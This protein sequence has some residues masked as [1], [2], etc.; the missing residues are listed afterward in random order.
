MSTCVIPGTAVSS[1]RTRSVT[2]FRVNGSTSPETAT[3]TTCCRT[4]ISRMTGFSVSIGK[5]VMAS[6][7]LLTSSTTRRASASRSSSIITVPIPSEAVDWICL[8]PSMPWIASSMR[9]FT[10]SSTSSGA[11]PRYGTSTLIRSSS[12]SGND[13]SRTFD[14]ASTPLTRM[15]AIIRLAATLL[16]ANQSIMRLKTASDRTPE[17]LHVPPS[18]CP[19]RRSSLRDRGGGEPGSDHSRCAARHGRR[20]RSSR[21]RAHTSRP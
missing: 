2:R 1:S 14:V 12:I 10:A 7:L 17:S 20:C 11:A 19:T 18:P 4:V 6:M 9:T 5:L 21:R 8:M 13:S 3:S 16:R 15:N